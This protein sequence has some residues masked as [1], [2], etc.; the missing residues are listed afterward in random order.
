MDWR[1]KILNQK[2]ERKKNQKIFFLMTRAKKIINKIMKID[3]Q[4]DH[5]TIVLVS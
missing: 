5:L 3:Y 4:N 1:K 2:I